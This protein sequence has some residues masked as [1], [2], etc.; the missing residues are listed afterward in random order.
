MLTLW[1]SLGTFATPAVVDT[2]ISD[3]VGEIDGTVKAYVDDKTS[4]IA[5][6]AALN[7]LTNRVSA[8][9]GE[10]DVLQ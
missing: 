8:A 10:I 4:G 1:D 5:S 3:K 2:K 9:E 7:A 6:D